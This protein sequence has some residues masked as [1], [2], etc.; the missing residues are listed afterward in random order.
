MIV[1]PSVIGSVIKQVFRKTPGIEFWSEPSANISDQVD[2]FARIGNG[3]GKDCVVWRTAILLDVRTMEAIKVHKFD[4]VL[5]PIGA[6]L[7]LVKDS[8]QRGREKGVEEGKV[9][10][11]EPFKLL[12]KTVAEA[13]R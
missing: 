12:A 1:N 9:I 11:M 2:I 7:D 10:A 4:E 6:L 3:L 5:R 13:F 8:E